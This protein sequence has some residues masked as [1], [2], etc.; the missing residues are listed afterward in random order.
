MLP[1][2]AI[3]AAS[4]LAQSPAPPAD[5]LKTAIEDG[6]RGIWYMNQPTK[7]Q[8]RYKYSGG[9]GTYPQ[10]HAPFAI[11]APA[12]R[13]T[14]FVYGGSGGN[15]SEKGD[16][17][18]HMVSYY[19]HRTGTVPRPV[20]ILHK[21]TEDA[22]DNPTISIDAKGHIYVFSAAH[23]TSR[24]AYI[25]RSRRPYDIGRWELLAKTNF[26]YTQPWFFTGANQFLFMHTLYKGGQRTLNFK[27]SPDARS[28]TA[29]TLLAHIEM[30]DYQI[31]WPHGEKLGTAFDMHPASGRGKGLNY[32]TN[33]YYVETGD[34]GK[35]WQ[36]AAG[37]TVKLPLTTAANA[38]LVHDYNVE[39]LNVYLKD[40]AYDR[41]GRPVIVYLTSKG[42]EPGEGS[43]PYQWYTVR[44][45][46]AKWVKLPVTTSDHNYDHGSMTIER[47]GTWRLVAPT[48]PGPQP[49]G[50]GGDMV[51]W[52]S[53]D[54]G[55]TWTRE[56]TL[57]QG[58]E[59]NHTYARKVVNAHP[60]FYTIWAD[61]SALEA[62]PSRLYF[63]ARDGKVYR[64]PAKMDGLTAKP[65][66][67]SGPT[68]Q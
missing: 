25:W 55:R 32:R 53:K 35:T 66:R 39:N 54:G 28:W 48:D 68:V 3:A 58:G 14:F 13:K 1:L 23:G 29:P 34:L 41:Q 61:G 47:D 60:D 30:G 42:W 12:V 40:L 21:M 24:P 8:H 6:Y 49:W 15:V 44:W 2:A 10:W 62:T 4:L 18:T 22:H 63:A 51:M 65:E 67:V 9:F 33:I 20:R 50:T 37:E 56:A 27:T 52:T 59:Y 38:A 31:T 17:L 11:Y 45:D 43:G 19:D 57:T 7:D 36:T 16:T 5:D 64:L 26:S 46:G